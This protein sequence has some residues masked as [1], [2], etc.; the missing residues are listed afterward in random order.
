MD[1]IL[2]RWKPSIFRD[3]TR[4]SL[5]VPT[6]YQLPEEERPQLDRGWNLKSHTD[7]WLHV[8]MGKE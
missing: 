1:K 3:V 5:T 7:R 4:G 6:T 2:A 8:L